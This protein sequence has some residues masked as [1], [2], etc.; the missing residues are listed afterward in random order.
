ML[1]DRAKESVDVRIVVSDGV[2]RT[3]TRNLSRLPDPAQVRSR[4]NDLRAGQ[5][6][7]MLPMRFG[8]LRALEQQEPNPCRLNRCAGC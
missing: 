4:F 3:L 8:T 7:L 6:E 5:R 2:R 1:L